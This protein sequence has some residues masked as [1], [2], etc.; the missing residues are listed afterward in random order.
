MENTVTTYSLG[1]MGTD[2]RNVKGEFHLAFDQPANGPETR[3]RSSAVPSRL[4]LARMR[5]HSPATARQSGLPSRAAPARAPYAVDTR[6]YR[7]ATEVAAAATRM[8]TLCP[9]SPDEHADLQ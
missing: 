4:A 8:V 3:A 9:L 1:S 7:R 5:P 2:L 6:A